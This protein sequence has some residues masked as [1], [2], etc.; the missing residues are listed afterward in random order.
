M[1]RGLGC[2]VAGSGGDNAAFVYVREVI[3]GVTTGCEAWSVLNGASVAHPGL[4]GRAFLCS[5]AMRHF[6]LSDTLEA[7]GGL[8]KGCSGSAAIP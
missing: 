8:L 5:R 6:P 4:N 3:P 7:P 1:R 2:G